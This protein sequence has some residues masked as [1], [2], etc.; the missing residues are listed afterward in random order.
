[1]N[2]YL[3]F[4]EFCNNDYRAVAQMRCIINVCDQYGFVALEK[5]LRVGI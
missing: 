4:V 2:D 3:I 1:M 5:C